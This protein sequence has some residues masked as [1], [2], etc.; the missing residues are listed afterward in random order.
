VKLVK[1]PTVNKP[2]LSK[3]I[4]GAKKPTII[5][6]YERAEPASRCGYYSYFDGQKWGLS[7]CTPDL[8]KS[9]KALSS[10]WQDIKW[11]GLAEASKSQASNQKVEADKRTSSEEGAANA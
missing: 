2:K 9:R 10:V 5:G 1:E 11:R 8:A 3:W 6:V 7:S 4:S